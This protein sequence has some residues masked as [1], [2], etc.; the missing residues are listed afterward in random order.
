MAEAVAGADGVLAAAASGAVPGRGPGG[1][2]AT[3]PGGGARW[4]CLGPAESFRD[5]NPHGVR[6]FGTDLVAFAG[7]AGAVRILDARCPHMGGDLRGGRVVGD[8][9]DCPVHQWRWDGSG[10]CIG[11]SP[12]LLPV[13]AWVTG[14]RDGLLYVR[15]AEG[16]AS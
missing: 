14:E 2:P 7:R 11:G 6:A 4:H 1:V 8:A 9:I 13:R 12:K 5:G 16:A 10:R 3:G 15:A